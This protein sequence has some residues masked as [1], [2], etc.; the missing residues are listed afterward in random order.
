MLNSKGIP[1]IIPVLPDGSLFV[2]S[3]Q[4]VVVVPIPLSQDYISH[5]NSETS[6]DSTE[7]FISLCQMTVH[8]KRGLGRGVEG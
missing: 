8:R 1:E 7:R 5:Q 3:S 2:F 4:S 6:V